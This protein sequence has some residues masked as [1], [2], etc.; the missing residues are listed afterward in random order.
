MFLPILIYRWQQGMCG[1]FLNKRMRLS[2]FGGFPSLSHTKQNLHVIT[3]FLEVE[4]MLQSVVAGVVEQTVVIP[5]ASG[6]RQ[7]QLVCGIGW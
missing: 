1:M 2:A 7:R 5:Q 6:S 4:G 3:R